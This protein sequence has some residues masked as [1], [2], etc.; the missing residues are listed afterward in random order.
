[1]REYHRSVAEQPLELIALPMSEVSVQAVHW[2][3]PTANEFA[4]YLIVVRLATENFLALGSSRRGNL[5]SMGKT[6]NNQRGQRLSRFV[7]VYNCS[8]YCVATGC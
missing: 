3:Y 4:L 1:M 6:S 7:S 2:D 5:D 8:Q